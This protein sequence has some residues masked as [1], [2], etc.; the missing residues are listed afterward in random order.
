[1]KFTKNSL[2]I[3]C[4]ATILLVGSI[5][6]KSGKK[7]VNSRHHKQVHVVRDMNGFN[8][9]IGTVFR[10]D[11]SVTTV[12]R[13]GNYRLQPPSNTISMSNSNT[14]TLPNVGFLGRRAEIVSKKKN[15]LKHIF[16]NIFFFKIT[17]FLF[18]HIFLSHIS[19]FSNL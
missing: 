16:C 18:L 8:T 1:M 15:I 14:S 13:L 7:K 4:I 19:L 2:F 10:K 3:L 6:S 5:T 11:P 17:Y 12:T 9:E